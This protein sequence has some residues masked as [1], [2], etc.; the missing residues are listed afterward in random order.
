VGITPYHI[1]RARKIKKLIHKEDIDL[2]LEQTIEKTL[3][4]KLPTLQ[5]KNMTALRLADYV[6]KISKSKKQRINRELQR[7]WNKSGRGIIDGMNC[8]A[9][10][11]KR[12]HYKYACK[13]KN[14]YKR[15]KY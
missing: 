1:K 5:Q 3:I 7:A 15:K 11:L 12:L 9:R 8:K 10:R 14:R 13:D 2:Q 4:S 6:A